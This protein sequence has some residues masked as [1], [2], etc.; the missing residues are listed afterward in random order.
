MRGEFHIHT[1]YSDGVLSVDQVLNYVKGKVDCI[2]ITDHDIL[3]GSIEAFHKSKELGI[4]CIVGVEISSFFQGDTVHILG[5]FKNDENLSELKKVLDGIREQR[6][7]RLYLMKDKLK[8]IFDIDLDLTEILKISTITR[9]SIARA[10]IKQ[11]SQYTT[12][13]LFSEVIG[14]GCPA[15]I[16][17]TKVDTQQAIDMIHKA[18][19]VAVLAHP[20]LL[21]TCKPIDIIKM[22]IDGIEAVYP[23]NKENEE[24]EFRKLAKEHNLFVTAGSDFHFFGDKSHADLLTHFIYDEELEIFKKK[25]L[26]KV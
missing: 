15:Y 16:P 12:E 4:C 22:G 9:G 18:G 26:E 24:E 7:E 23:R 1:I 10:I 6:V 13:Y 8:D 20:T 14:N 17:S 3:D 19:G 5:Y 21:R 11:Y 25:V 2:S